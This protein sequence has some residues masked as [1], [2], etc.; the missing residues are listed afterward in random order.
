MKTSIQSVE[1]NGPETE[2]KPETK[3][4]LPNP[5][6][7]EKLRLNPAYLETTKVKRIRTILTGRPSSQTYI[8]VHPDASY[9][10][11][12][13][14]LEMKEDREDFLVMPELAP[15]LQGEVI[16]KIIY[17]AITR[18]GVIYLWSVRIQHP[19]ERQCLWWQSGHEAAELAMTKWIRVIPDMDTGS[20]EKWEAE[21]EIPEPQWSEIAPFEELLRQAYQ[22]RIIRDLDHPAIKQLRGL[23]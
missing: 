15:Q 22:N 7:L 21:H 17:T 20:Y 16:H 12:F 18:K 13:T 1:S 2:A 11:P 4:E 23:A 19:D 14:M 10:C 9:R 3:V 8:R 5:F 6:S